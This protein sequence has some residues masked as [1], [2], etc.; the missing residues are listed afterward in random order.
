MKF[1]T[2]VINFLRGGKKALIH[3]QFKNFLEEVEANLK[4]LSFQCESR[5]LSSGKEQFFCLRN[6]ILRFLREE[7]I[8]ADTTE[9]ENQLTNENMLS[10]IAFLADFTKH[11]NDLNLRLQRK[12]KSISDVFRSVCG[13]Q[14]QLNLFKLEISREQLHHFH[15][16]EEISR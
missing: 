11:L 16:C 9:F 8:N 4:D 5:W 2:K 3:R 1:V 12:D 6:E 10:E 7:L 14:N 15:C 13:F